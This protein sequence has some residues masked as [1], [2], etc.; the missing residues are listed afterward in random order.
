MRLARLLNQRFLLFV[1]ALV[2]GAA[3]AMPGYA[4]QNSFRQ[5]VN[6][7]L[8]SLPF[9][10]AQEEGIFR[11]NGLNVDTCISRGGVQQRAGSGMAIPPQHVCRRQ[12]TGPDIN[13]EL[14]EGNPDA[15]PFAISGGGPRVVR[16]MKEGR[17]A[18]TVILANFDP[19]TNWSIL[20]RKEIT[21]P[22]QLKGKRLGITGYSNINGFMALLFVQA[23]GWDPKSSDIHI[24]YGQ[25]ELENL[26][27]GDIDAAVV[28]SSVAVP[29]MAQGFNRLVDMRDWKIPMIGN[30]L[31]VDRTW[32]RNNRE[33]ALR[34]VKSMVD[35]IA[36][37]KKD[38]QVAYRAMANWYGW[39]DPKQQAELYTYLTELPS[40]P[41]PTEE[42]IVRYLKVYFP[43]EVWPLEPTAFYDDGLLRE[44]DKS[45][46]I[47][48]L[49]K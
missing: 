26:R 9:I 12:G 16:Q 46:Y 6:I 8:N 28:V 25:R 38:R 19:V 10:V 34:F 39:T 18:N 1:V 42:Q 45:G 20:S 47:D 29:G 22:V 23:M 40:K 4:Q 30:S 33:T 27:K 2:A 13:D 41:Y 35:A 17:L 15:G 44:L 32:L 21:E 14:S 7:E 36:L 31:H 11:R 5:I 3:A 37:I 48:G 49:Y 43:A 24:V